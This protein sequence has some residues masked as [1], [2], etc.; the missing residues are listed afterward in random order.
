MPPRRRRPDYPHP[1][2]RRRRRYRR[3]TFATLFLLALS[4]ILDR[5]GMFRHTG[6]DWRSFDHKTFLVTRVIDGDTL[7]LRP[8]DG[9]PETRVRLLGVDA[10]ELRSRDSNRPDH[11]AHEARR[12][13]ESRAEG[14]AVTLRL[15]QT[16]TRDRY[17]RLLAYVYASDS[18]NLNLELVR[19][20]HAYADRRFPHS[21]RHQFERAENEARR[22]RRGLWK[23]VKEEQMPPWR[24][25]W[26]ARQGRSRD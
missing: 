8:A 6:D 14:E 1:Q 4:A 3:I 18:D 20:G 10:P 5:A 2:L 7:D 26:L 17:Q 9:G 16:E 19:N 25:E 12:H 11:W 21:M 23:D 22:A 13:A 15:E 24:R